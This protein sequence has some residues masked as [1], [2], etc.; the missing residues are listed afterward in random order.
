MHLGC[1]LCHG[2]PEVVNYGPNPF[3][4][5]FSATSRFVMEQTFLYWKPFY[6]MDLRVCFPSKPV[7][8]RPYLTFFKRSFIFHKLFKGKEAVF[9]DLWNMSLLYCLSRINRKWKVAK[10]SQKYIN[11]PLTYLELPP[12]WAVYFCSTTVEQPLQ[13]MVCCIS[14]V[15]YD[16]CTIHYN[17]PMTCLLGLPWD[18]AMSNC[19]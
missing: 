15:S 11:N 16:R 8:G 14:V 2:K 7:K 3:N 18:S 6:G 12:T 17:F 1:T 5:G 13:V 4:K 10:V 9:T 19:C